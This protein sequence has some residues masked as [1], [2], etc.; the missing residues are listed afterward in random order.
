[1]GFCD[2]S[3][4]KQH[5]TVDKCLQT[6]EWICNSGPCHSQSGWSVFLPQSI[7]PVALTSDFHLIDLINSALIWTGHQDM[8]KPHRLLFFSC[9]DIVIN[10][11]MTAHYKFLMRDFEIRKGGKRLQFMTWSDSISRD[12]PE[13]PKLGIH[14]LPNIICMLSYAS[15][16]HQSYSYFPCHPGLFPEKYHDTS[17]QFL[18]YGRRVFK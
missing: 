12:P 2:A 18:A 1:M 4:D 16:E 6:K 5:E 10:S 14:Q 9:L 11:W 8:W 3:P 13:K 7:A 15:P 17:S